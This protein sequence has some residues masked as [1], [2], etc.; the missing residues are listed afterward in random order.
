MPAQDAYRTFNTDPTC[1]DYTH[2]GTAAGTTTISNAPCF[3][4]HLQIN[5]R[6]ASGTVI[7]YDSAGTSGTTLGTIILGTQ[8]SSDTPAP[9]TYKVRTK[10]CLTISNSAGVDLVV[11]AIS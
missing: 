9:F 7:M 6:A 3:F 1:Y 5:Q 8:T 4:S 2:M 10:N 11:A